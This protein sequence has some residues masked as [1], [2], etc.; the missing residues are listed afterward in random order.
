M[1]RSNSSETSSPK[2]QKT[3]NIG[4]QSPTQSPTESP[5]TVVPTRYT[6]KSQT[7][8]PTKTNNA[9]PGLNG[10]KVVNLE[11]KDQT[12]LTNNTFNINV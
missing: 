7:E 11:F 6:V 1:P 12:S 8:P 2:R 3:V 9:E 4:S 10:G 5:V